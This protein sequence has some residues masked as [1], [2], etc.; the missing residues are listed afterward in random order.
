MGIFTLSGCLIFSIKFLPLIDSTSELD[1]RTMPNMEIFIAAVAETTYTKSNIP[2][3]VTFKNVDQ[4]EE[5]RIIR[6]FEPLPVFFTFSMIDEH[7][8]YLDIPGAGKVDLYHGAI[9]YILLSPGETFT[10]DV[11]LAQH[12]IN[13]QK[14]KA[15]KYAV[16]VTYHNQYGENCFRGEII[17]KPISLIVSSEP[18]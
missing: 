17:S 7:G 9:D 13:P 1:Y 8:K 10:L 6:Q 16:S 14:V 15:G 12:L 2:L 11:N 5:I 4:T 18:G 3:K